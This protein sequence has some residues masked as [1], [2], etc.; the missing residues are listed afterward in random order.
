MFEMLLIWLGTTVTSV[1]MSFIQTVGIIKDLSDAGYKLDMDALSKF[2]EK[3]NNNN[4]N[5]LLYF[6]IPFV[7]MLY[8]YDISIKYN[9][10]RYFILDQ[11]RVLGLIEKMSDAERK[12]YEKNPTGLHVYGM[13]IKDTINKEEDKLKIAPTVQPSKNEEPIKT[14]EDPKLKIAPTVQLSKNEEP[15]KTVEDP[16]LKEQESLSR[17]ERIEELKK[18]REELV[19]D[20]NQKGKEIQKIKH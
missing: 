10:N 18:M 17:S 6:L 15:I 20:S 5:S 16:K 7:N 14:V 2:K 19:G 4:N 12:E 11:C 3:N 1:G 9:N 13:L 8:V